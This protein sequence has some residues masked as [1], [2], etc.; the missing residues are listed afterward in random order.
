MSKVTVAMGE[1]ALPEGKL[2]DAWRYTLDQQ[3]ANKDAVVTSG[4][5][6]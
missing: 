5:E 1:A 2:V 3:Y 6:T 4:A